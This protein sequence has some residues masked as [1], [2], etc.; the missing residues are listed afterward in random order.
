[1]LQRMLHRLCRSLVALS[2]KALHSTEV[3]TVLTYLKFAWPKSEVTQQSVCSKQFAKKIRD[4]P[5]EIFQMTLQ[6]TLLSFRFQTAALIASFHRWLHA[7][8]GTPAEETGGETLQHTIKLFYVLWC[9]MV[10]LWIFKFLKS[11]LNIRYQKHRGDSTIW[12]H[13]SAIRALAHSRT[14]TGTRCRWLA[15]KKRK[16]QILPRSLRQMIPMQMRPGATVATVATVGGCVLYFFILKAIICHYVADVTLFF[17]VPKFRFHGLT[18]Q[19]DL[20]NTI[21]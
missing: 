9:F 16:S 17:W 2:T 5:E 10:I 7:S 13:D 11:P 12:S 18:E 19:E 8:K 14:G 4:L 1:M 20:A 15:Q 6:M 21:G 3:D